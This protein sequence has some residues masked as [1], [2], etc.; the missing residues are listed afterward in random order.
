MQKDPRPVFRH[1]PKS[2]EG[3]GGCGAI[4]YPHPEKH[5][6]FFRYP[7]HS[8]IQQ[9]TAPDHPR[10]PTTTA[11][12]QGTE[13]AASTAGIADRNTEITQQAAKPLQQQGKLLIADYIPPN[14]RRRSPPPSH[15]RQT[16]R[17]RQAGHPAD[18]RAARHPAGAAVDRCLD[19]CLYTFFITWPYLF[20]R[21]HHFR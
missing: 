20:C 18:H 5:R 15:P 7:S 12:P 6:P 16:T 19:T 13:T 14:C 8:L 1:P 9:P 3:W 11:Q 10:R 2:M 4:L 17:S 21:F